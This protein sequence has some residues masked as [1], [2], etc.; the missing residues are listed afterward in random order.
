MTATAQAA[1]RTTPIAFE[2]PGGVHN[3][4]PSRL[5]FGAGASARVAEEVERLGAQRALVVSI[6]GREPLAREIAAR[7]GGRCV[8]VMPKAVFQV[9]PAQFSALFEGL[10]RRAVR[11]ERRRRPRLAG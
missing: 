7:I 10:D 6:P 5:V 3:A 8:G 11:A 4:T 9:S 2:T 1:I